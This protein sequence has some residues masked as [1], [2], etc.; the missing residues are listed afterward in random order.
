MTART[1]LWIYGSSI[2][3]LLPLFIPLWMI[4]AIN[5]HVE[6]LAWLDGITITAILIFWFGCWMN[7]R[8][9]PWSAKAVLAIALIFVPILFI[10]HGWDNY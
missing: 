2:S 7:P 9:I 4:I 8:P 6:S 10:A 3:A 5:V 1:H